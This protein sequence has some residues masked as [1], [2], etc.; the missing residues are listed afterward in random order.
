MSLSC[1]V[2]RIQQ[3]VF[4]FKKVNL[5]DLNLHASALELAFFPLNVQPILVSKHLIAF[6]LAFSHSLILIDRSFFKLFSIPSPGLSSSLL[7]FFF[8]FLFSGIPVA[9]ELNL[10]SSVYH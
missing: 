8:F 7:L 9:G 5:M 1:S 3:V 2:M 10:L 6:S 4:R